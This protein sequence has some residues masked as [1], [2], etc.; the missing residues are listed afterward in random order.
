MK[1]ITS[2]DPTF[3]T[4]ARRKFETPR[5]YEVRA[6]RDHR[7]VDLISDTL[8]L[9][10]LWYAEPNA[11]NNAIGCGK[12]F[13]WSDAVIRVYDSA[14]QRDRTT[15]ARGRFPRILITSSQE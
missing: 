13:S 15:R 12:F 4:A 10:R 3:N 14:R 7:G 11:I 9:D 8:P 2:H 6:R 5:L 1:P